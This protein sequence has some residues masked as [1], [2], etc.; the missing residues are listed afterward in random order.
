MYVMLVV[1]LL[2]YLLSFEVL[3]KIPGLNIKN[4]LTQ[5]LPVLSLP[6]LCC[7]AI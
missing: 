3:F 6:G 2:F 5:H 7:L 1:L 4:I